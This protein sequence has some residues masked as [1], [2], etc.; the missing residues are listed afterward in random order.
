MVSGAPTMAT[1]E[2]LTIMLVARISILVMEL[3]LSEGT[4]GGLVL[5]VGL[6]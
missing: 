4:V 3:V 5:K 2:G 6:F 1:G